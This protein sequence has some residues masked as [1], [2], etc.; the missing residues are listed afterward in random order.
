[1]SIELRQA[2]DSDIARIYGG[3]GEHVVATVD[4]EPTTDPPAKGP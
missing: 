1:M 4:G 2:T 3:E